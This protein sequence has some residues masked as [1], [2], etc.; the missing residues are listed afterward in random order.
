[1]RRFTAT[2]GALALTTGVLFGT[3]GAASAQTESVPLLR[4]VGSSLEMF[5]TTGLCVLPRNFPILGAP[6]AS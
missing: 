4:C 5:A 6:V 3:A 1:M 2:I